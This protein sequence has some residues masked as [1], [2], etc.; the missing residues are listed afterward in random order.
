MR[1]RVL[2]EHHL[3]DFGRLQRVDHEGRF[4]RR[5]GDDVDLLALQLLHH[6]LDAAAAHTHTGTDRIDGAVVGDHAD[7]GA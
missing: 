6:G 2:I 7:L 1:S 5:P 4:V 3:G